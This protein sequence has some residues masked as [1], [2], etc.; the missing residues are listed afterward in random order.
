[1]L[2][3]GQGQIAKVEATHDELRIKV[4]GKDG[5]IVENLTIKARR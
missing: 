2:A 4:V 1:M 3:L 5:A